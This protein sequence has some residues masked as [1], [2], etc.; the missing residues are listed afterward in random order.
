MLRRQPGRRDP[1]APAPAEADAA[2][3]RPRPVGITMEE[4]TGEA[5]RGRRGVPAKGP[6]PQ[7]GVLG[8]RARSPDRRP[9]R[10]TPRPGT[11]EAE[12]RD[13]GSWDGLRAASRGPGRGPGGVQAG[14]HHRTHMSGSLPEHCSWSPALLP[15]TSALHLNESLRKVRLGEL[16]PGQ[17]SV[18]K[19]VSRH[20]RSEAHSLRVTVADVA[21]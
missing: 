6:G 2:V 5:S 18:D 11:V 10:G 1:R 16:L 12:C 19:G 15:L 7:E 14:P 17:D 8:S 13:V 4:G 20:L 21:S 9:L 3:P